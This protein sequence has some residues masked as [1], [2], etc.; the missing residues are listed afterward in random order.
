MQWCISVQA[1]VYGINIF[2]L[3]I[4]QLIFSFLRLI[5]LTNTM[6]TKL[7]TIPRD[8]IFI[9]L[10]IGNYIYTELFLYN[11]KTGGQVV[12]LN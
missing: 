7:V 6:Y 11:I 1:N 3:S 4:R 8:N 5:N 9:C 10:V 2:P 12:M